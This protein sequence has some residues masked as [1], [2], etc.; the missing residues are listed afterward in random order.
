M[1]ADLEGTA[2]EQLTKSNLSSLSEEAALSTYMGFDNQLQRPRDYATENLRHHRQVPGFTHRGIIRGIT[3]GDGY[4]AWGKL[5]LFHNNNSIHLTGYLKQ[6]QNEQQDTEDDLATSPT[7]RSPF[8]IAERT[9][10]RAQEKIHQRRAARAR[11]PAG[12]THSHIVETI[13]TEDDQ[14]M[15]RDEE[16]NADEIE[17][18]IRFGSSASYQNWRSRWPHPCAFGKER[19]NGHAY[20]TTDKQQICSF[21][22]ANANWRQMQVPPCSSKTSTKTTTRAHASP[23]LQTSVPRHRGG[24]H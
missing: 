4:S 23:G 6:Y 9:T 15:E 18:L 17:T 20:N 8:D 16:L 14:R 10:R 22:R 21:R 19:D 7:T 12:W 11:Y 13:E 5:V 3:Q 24:D 2:K 1:L